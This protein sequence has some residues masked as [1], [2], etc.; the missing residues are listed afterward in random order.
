MAMLQVK[1]IGRISY[2]H[3]PLMHVCRFLPRDLRLAKF[4][5][6]RWVLSL[7]NT[8]ETALVLFQENRLC[9]HFLPAAPMHVETFTRARSFQVLSFLCE[10]KVA[11]RTLRLVVTTR[12]RLSF[13]KFSATPRTSLFN[14][15]G[16]TGEWPFRS[17][18][19]DLFEIHTDMWL[20]ILLASNSCCGGY[21]L[22]SSVTWRWPSTLQDS[23]CPWQRKSGMQPISNF[24]HAAVDA[25]VSE[26]GGKLRTELGFFRD[27][28]WWRNV[29]L[30]DNQWFCL[31]SAE[32]E[33]FQFSLLLLRT[34]YPKCSW[35]HLI[36]P[37]CPAHLFQFPYRAVRPLY[38]RAT[39]K[40]RS[41]PC[42]FWAKAD[43]WA[44][45]ARQQ[46]HVLANCAG[47]FAKTFPM[48]DFLGTMWVVLDKTHIFDPGGLFSKKKI[49]IRAWKKRTDWWGKIL[50]TV[51]E[52]IGT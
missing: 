13:L 14:V 28:Q 40:Q 34:N 17:R 27:E 5:R 18:V 47:C 23:E 2:R 38:T 4:L 9:V 7:R 42:H 8:A 32:I 31:W 19:Q 22:L 43:P 36:F 25:L 49:W 35:E 24:N 6:E 50:L 51:P 15:D 29:P 16:S 46:N 33:S 20:W 10:L 21:L 12:L 1:Q 41:I 39:R 45:V 11:W 30:V 37:G 52:I 26:K 44:Q 3:K 48:S